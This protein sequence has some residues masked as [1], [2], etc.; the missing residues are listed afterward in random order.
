MLMR[1]LDV[2]LVRLEDRILLTAEPTATIVGPLDGTVELGSDFQATVTF[3][4]TH[5]T[6]V[7]FGPYVDL[8]LPSGIDGD[9]TP[10]DQTDD[11]GITFTSATFLGVPLVST[12]LVFDA[13]GEATHP[14]AVDNMGDAVTVTGTPGDTLVVLQLPF[15]S[16]APDQ[17]PSEIILNLTMSE[18]ADLLAP[19]D[20]SV[21]G[22]F[23]FGNDALDNPTFPDP[24]IIGPLD[25]IS[26]EPVVM[27]FEKIYIGPEDET[28]TGPNFTRF[29]ELQV[30]IAT[31][32]T[33]DN[34]VIEDF[35]P[36]NI[37]PIQHVNVMGT[38]TVAFS[39]GTG[40]ATNGNIFS[41]DFGSITGVD[42]VDAVVRIEYY[43]P[44][45]DADGDRI[46]DQN[47]GDDATVINNGQA[48][49]DFIPNDVR[50]AP[51]SLVD[52]DTLIDHTLEAA[53]IVV[54][55]GSTI[56]NDANA[57]GLSPGDTIEYTLEVQV[58]DYFTFDNIVLDD[59]M[60]DGQRL[61]LGF[62]PTFSF[63]ERGA[64]NS[65][66]FNIGAALGPGVTLAHNIDSPGS[67]QTFLNFDLSTAIAGVAPD[68]VLE[69]GLANG[70]F[71]ATTATIVYRAIVQDVYTDQFPSGEQEVGQGDRISNTVDVTGD[72][73][74]NQT[75]VPTGFSE[76]DD[77]ADAL[78]IATGQVS[79]AIY[80]V[81]GNTGFTD[82][83]IA[84]GDDITFRLTYVL[85]LS[86]VEN[87]RVVDFLPLPVFDVDL[88]DQA[89]AGLTFKRHII[90]PGAC[91]R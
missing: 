14:Y 82:L 75:L 89:S 64:S 21:N 84:P 47:N 8:F 56:F 46:I 57:A 42:G 44:E 45:F 79:K 40:T 50:D 32:Q 76:S 69:G 23:Q 29:Y 48:T 78:D 5:A 4:N 86:T 71:G 15:G 67:G 12:E 61:D 51:I 39:N 88:P 91:R 19:L 6:D 41:A 54:Q 1:N 31:G 2:P 26:V 13:S 22:G 87:L 85:P 59:V 30:D 81:N 52:D 73:L 43:V 74:T 60:S 70:T 90:G 53:S 77:S 80:A 58:S 37:I 72:V 34:V 25:S 55:K 27:D 9:D 16:F 36:N 63:N 62:T 28:A 7:G 49:G 3:D 10:A 35:L 66:T 11:D 65:G 24:T 17:T 38:P 68:G 18:D 33:V 83:D 20:I